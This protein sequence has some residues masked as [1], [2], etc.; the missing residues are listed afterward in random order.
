MFSLVSIIQEDLPSTFL[1]N[2]AEEAQAQ[3]RGDLT[4]DKQLVQNQ[5]RIH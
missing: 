3:P 2:P 1:I 5:W 4:R